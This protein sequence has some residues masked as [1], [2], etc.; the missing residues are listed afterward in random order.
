ME[1]IG[2]FSKVQ[3]NGWLKHGLSSCS[4]GNS[5]VAA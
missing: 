5:K 1:I 2:A 4:K 3:S